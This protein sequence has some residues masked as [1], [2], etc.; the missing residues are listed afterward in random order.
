MNSLAY[1]HWH[2]RNLMSHILVKERTSALGFCPTND[3]TDI[4][5]FMSMWCP[6]IV[7]IKMDKYHRFSDCILSKQAFSTLITSTVPVFIHVNHVF[8]VQF[9]HVLITSLLIVFNSL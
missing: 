2:Y 1:L 6:S 3:S 7:A 5:M 8:F 9:Y 4:V